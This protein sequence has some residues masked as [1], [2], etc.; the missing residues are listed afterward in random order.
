MFSY[1]PVILAAVQ[2][3]PQSIA[4]VIQIMQTIDATCTDGDGLKWFNWL[5][6]RVTKAVDARVSSGG[7]SNPSW[8]AALDVQFARFYFTALQ[9]SLSGLPTPGCWR[10]L[11]A[12]RSET[13]TA[14]IQFAMAGINA[15]INHDLCEA[16]VA[17]DRLTTTIPIHGTTEYNDY[18]AL[19]STLDAIIQT[20]EQELHVRLLGEELPLVS[21]L[22]D[23]LAAWS[24]AA[25]RESAWNNAELLWHLS[26]LPQL[27][28]SFMD[29]LDGLTTVASKA[30]LVP[31]P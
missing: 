11:F 18:T 2:T 8:I 7:F 26:A 29:S 13:N 28:D 22:D 16:I 30:I 17:T 10:A 14:R 23:V 1:D 25:A 6:L 4:D 15:H 9:T 21:H 12:Q 19:N 5:Y 24:V 31:V 3:I 27:A 20:A